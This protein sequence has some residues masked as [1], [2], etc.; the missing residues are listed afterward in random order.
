MQLPP[1]T[2]L[3]TKLNTSRTTIRAVLEHLDETKIVLW[4]GR[5]KTVL[6][7]PKPQDYFSIEETRSASE[8]VEKLFMNFILGG[9]LAPGTILRE[10]ELAREFGVSSSAIREYLI[11]FSRF[12]L[13]EKEPN[14]HWVLLGFTR[15]FA[16]ELSDVREDFEFRALR[17]FFERSMAPQVQKEL[18]DLEKAHCELLE[19]IESDYLNFSRLD[20]RFH[21]LFIEG[22]NNRFIEDFYELISLIFHYHYRWKK[23]DEKERNFRATN[24]HLT[25]IRA[26]INNDFDAAKDGYALHLNSARSTLLD[27]V[28]WD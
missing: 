25:V 14:R 17:N 9:D 21:R 26:L 24:E 2:E 11:R 12:G 7:A 18:H 13:I 16:E 15:N 4:E 23:T 19:N 28:T 20:E 27:S 3:A 8:K 22:L 5:K 10:S 1:E 6:R